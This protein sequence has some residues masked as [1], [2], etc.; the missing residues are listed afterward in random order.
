MPVVHG[1]KSERSLM[2]FKKFQTKKRLQQWKVP[3]ECPLV[4][5]LGESARRSSDRHCL[6]DV[7]L[8]VYTNPAHLLEPM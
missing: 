4:L 6:A 2:G 1:L 8:M 7:E 5:V 3:L